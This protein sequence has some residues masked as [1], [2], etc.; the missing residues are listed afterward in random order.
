MADLQHVFER[1]V[2]AVTVLALSPDSLQHRLAEAFIGEKLIVLDGS[3]FPEH[4]RNK[5]SELRDGMRDHGRRR[6]DQVV[7]GMTAREAEQYIRIIIDLHQ[8][9]AK[10]VLCGHKD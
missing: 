6:I 7:R 4:L 1:L 3:D 2:G 8:G 5:F 9:V 10:E